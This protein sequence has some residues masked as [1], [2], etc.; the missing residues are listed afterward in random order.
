[1]TSTSVNETTLESKIPPVKKDPHLIPRQYQRELLFKA[2]DGNVIAVM[3]TGS[4]KT[5]VAVMLIQEMLRREKEAQ[6]GP[7]EVR[8]FNKLIDNLLRDPY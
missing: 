2:V 3:D 5:L 8:Y 6:R 4:G 1:M 7:K